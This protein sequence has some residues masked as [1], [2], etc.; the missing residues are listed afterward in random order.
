MASNKTFSKCETHGIWQH[1]SREKCRLS[2]KCDICKAELKTNIGST[3]GLH[4]DMKRLH[5][6]SLLKRKT[7]ACILCTELRSSQGDEALDTA[8]PIRAN[9]KAAKLNENSQRLKTI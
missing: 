2:A 5:G 7:S 1:F 8:F 4:E 6:V 9:I 3:K